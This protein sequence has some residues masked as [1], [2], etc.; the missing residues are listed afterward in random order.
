MGKQIL[1]H[2]IQLA[3]TISLQKN[4]DIIFSISEIVV[5]GGSS[6]AII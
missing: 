2:L 3:A 6:K 5:L 4:P 1:F